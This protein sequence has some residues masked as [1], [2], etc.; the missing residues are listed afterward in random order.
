MRQN[1]MLFANSIEKP[2]TVLIFAE[3]EGVGK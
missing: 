2:G 3:A 1:V